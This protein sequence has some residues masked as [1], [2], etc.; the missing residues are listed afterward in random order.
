MCIHKIILT[1]EGKF[2]FSRQIRPYLWENR[3]NVF[4]LSSSPALS[5]SLKRRHQ[6]WIFIMSEERQM[7]L[8]SAFSS[9]SLSLFRPL[10]LQSVKRTQ[11][12]LKK[13]LCGKISVLRL[14]GVYH[15]YARG[16]PCVHSTSATST[17]SSFFSPSLPP[18]SSFSS[19][20][21]CHIDSYKYL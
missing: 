18:S 1:S 15:K 7:S 13:Q 20:L 21:V 14:F 5:L 19:P 6:H 8:F 17:L 16:S 11:R 10:H 12:R 3:R 2:L 4:M 9:S